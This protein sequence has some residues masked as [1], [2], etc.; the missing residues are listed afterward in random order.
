MK[1]VAERYYQ[2]LNSRIVARQKKIEELKTK[3]QEEIQAPKKHQEKQAPLEKRQQGL[4][5]GMSFLLGSHTRV[6]K[7][8]SYNP[9]VHLLV[10]IICLSYYVMCDTLSNG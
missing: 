8:A 2:D 3:Q 6:T 5:G 10:G 7:A 1:A 4:Y 9:M